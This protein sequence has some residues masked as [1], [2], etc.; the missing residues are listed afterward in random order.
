MHRSGTSALAGV[1]SKL[2]CELPATPMAASTSN[3]KG[4]FESVAVRDFNEEVLASASSS[5]DDFTPFHDG[6]LQ[7]PEA[8]A[9]I[10]RAVALL[11]SEFGD[12]PLFV[13]KDPR[14]CRI[15]PFW[16][17]VLE[18]YG[19]AVKPILTIRNPL[20]VGDSLL[21]KK[22][23]TEPLSQMI[24]LRH[25]LDAERSTRGMARFHTSFE[26]LMVGWESV[27]EKAQQS[28]ELI[29]PKPIANV[30]LDVQLFLSGEL[31][32]HEDPTA[33]AVTSAL[34]PAWLRDTYDILKRWAEQGENPA[35]HPK[36]DRIKAE[37]DIASNAF[38]RIVRSERDKVLRLEEQHLALER[39]MAEQQAATKA[40]RV[41]LEEQ[42][43]MAAKAG[44]I[45]LDEQRAATEAARLAI[46]EQQ[47]AVS[48]ERLALEERL[49]GLATEAEKQRQAFEAELSAAGAN[50][51][52]LEESLREQASASRAK[53]E[54][55]EAQLATVSAEAEQE[56]ARLKGTVQDQGRRNTLMAAE[57]HQLME[58]R[59][60]LEAEL[61]ASRAR[62]KEAARLIAR[63]DAEIQ[64]RY[65][66]L[67]ALQRRILRSS[68]SWRFKQ[69]W[70]RAKRLAG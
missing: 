10:E 29:W 27:A 2:G 4:F 6:W 43:Q 49:A 38:A 45:A 22:N 42:R 36:L 52:R 15:V 40:E 1:L 56:V 32:H 14:I 57:L 8:P 39:S 24:W 67:A 48:A 59:E 12:S 65:E 61:I 50:A 31:R 7:S 5:W 11:R 3:A 18:R 66:E 33:R 53:Q 26:Q 34:L 35:D 64:T 41:L 51:D 30:E 69:L 55:L 62:R 70:R 25:A 68:P 58:A 20:E 63:R 16:T 54:R 60:A 21:R 19:C 47:A 37:F 46:A 23:F 28:L 13:L 9:F 17:A 44:Q